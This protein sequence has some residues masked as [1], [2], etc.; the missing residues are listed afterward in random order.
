MG[1][2]MSRIE[3]A[4]AI[5]A[6]QKALA[7]REAAQELLADS[8]KVVREMTAKIRVSHPGFIKHFQNG[9]VAKER[10]KS[11]TPIVRVPRSEWEQPILTFMKGIRTPIGAPTVAKHFKV[12]CHTMTQRLRSLV[13]TKHLRVIKDTGKRPTFT[14]A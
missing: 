11:S 12:P 4:D 9:A 8:E 14:V 13:E 1:E 10:K 2:K 5:I 7:D 6:L 3:L